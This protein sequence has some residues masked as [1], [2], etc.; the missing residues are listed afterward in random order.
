MLKILI[1]GFELIIEFE[2]DQNK[3]LERLT[4]ISNL[5]LQK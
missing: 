4:S 5:E 1:I 3:Q 2:K